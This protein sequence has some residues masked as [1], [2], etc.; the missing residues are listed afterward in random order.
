MWKLLQRQCS[1]S[2][3]VAAYLFQR[4]HCL[5]G[6]HQ[7]QVH[8]QFGAFSRRIICPYCRGDWLKLSHPDG[9]MWN[10]WGQDF[11]LLYKSLG[12]R[13]IPTPRQ[14]ENVSRLDQMLEKYLNN[15]KKED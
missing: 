15:G 4:A 3:S 10:S 2:K 13:I 9:E 12:F 7:T 1:A 11:E 5:L 6:Q 8:Q 14:K